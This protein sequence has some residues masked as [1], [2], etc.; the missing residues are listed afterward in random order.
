MRPETARL[1]QP[2][3]AYG[4]ELKQRLG[5]GE[6]PDL[7]AEQAA[8]KA[9]LQNDLYARQWPAF[10][11]DSAGNFLGARYALV[12]WLDEL[13]TLHSPWAEAWIEQKLEESL[14]N[15]NDRAWKFWEQAEKAAEVPDALEAYYL[16]VMLGF[17][18]THYESPGRLREYRQAWE[19]AFEPAQAKGPELPPQGTFEPNV[20][21]LGGRALFRAMA[22]VWAGTLFVLVPLLTVFAIYRLIE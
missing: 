20:G 21:E 11:G 6:T 14:Y 3:L 1:V 5:R 10:G 22:M 12:C 18:G 16:C 17:R 7:E 8:L 2:V 13:F 15:T 4:W 19:R 9:L